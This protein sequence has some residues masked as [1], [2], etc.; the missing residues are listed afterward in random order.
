[1]WKKKLKIIYCLR[2]RNKNNARK[3]SQP[4]KTIQID[5]HNSATTGKC[6]ER[7]FFEFFYFFFVSMALPLVTDFSLACNE[8]I[9]PT[10]TSKTVNRFGCGHSSKKAGGGQQGE[11]GEKNP[12]GQ[13][14]RVKRSSM[15]T[16]RRFW[17]TL[18]GSYDNAFIAS[19]RKWNRRFF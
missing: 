3:F 12:T 18:C 8:A 7:Y 11:R 9:K 1:M 15:D 6:V 16:V 13:K 5:F 4:A 2:R 19:H 10:R 17:E 14:L